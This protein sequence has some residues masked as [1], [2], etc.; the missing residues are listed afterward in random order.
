MLSMHVASRPLT[1]EDVPQSKLAVFQTGLLLT[2]MF[3]LHYV[4]STVFVHNRK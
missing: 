3:V 4:Y 2:S 1:R